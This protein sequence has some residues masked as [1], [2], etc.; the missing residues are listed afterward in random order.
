MPPDNCGMLDWLNS[1]GYVEGSQRETKGELSFFP[2]TLREDTTRIEKWSEKMKKPFFQRQP[3]HLCWTLPFPQGHFCI[4]SSPPTQPPTLV[5]SVE[6]GGST[7]SAA[8][9]RS[10]PAVVAERCKPIDRDHPCE[11][12]SPHLTE[13]CWQLLGVSVVLLVQWHPRCSRNATY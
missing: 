4:A 5:I 8:W 10:H 9:E 12:S 6:G 1:S 3:V 11:R 13:T 2:L 7:A